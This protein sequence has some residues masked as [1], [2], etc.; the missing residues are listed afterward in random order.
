MTVLAFFATQQPNEGIKNTHCCL[1]GIPDSICVL[2]LH[3]KEDAFVDEILIG[4][5]RSECPHD[6][7][8]CLQATG[9]PPSVEWRIGFEIPERRAFL[10]VNLRP[11]G[12]KF[13]L[14]ELPVAALLCSQSYRSCHVGF[15]GLR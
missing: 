11:Q 12:G 3:E 15:S 4:A 13:N 10:V 9:T 1:C 7:S 2:V 8:R 14:R 6:Q 5:A